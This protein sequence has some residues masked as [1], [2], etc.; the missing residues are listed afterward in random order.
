MVQTRLEDGRE[1]YS[2][3]AH[4]QS[5]VDHLALSCLSYSIRPAI[6]DLSD[7]L[8]KRRLFAPNFNLFLSN[9]ERGGKEISSTSSVVENIDG[10]YGIF[11]LELNDT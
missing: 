11:K 4:D 10:L 2:S 8:A 1:H 7:K 6:R 3:Q 9:I 5:S